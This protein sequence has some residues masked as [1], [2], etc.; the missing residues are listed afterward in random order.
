MLYKI[1][2]IVCFMST[3]VLGFS[4]DASSDD[5]EDANENVTDSAVFTSAE[6]VPGRLLNMKAAIAHYGCKL[7]LF[8]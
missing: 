4:I 8:N 1:L 6:E 3:G 5:F 2:P 7:I